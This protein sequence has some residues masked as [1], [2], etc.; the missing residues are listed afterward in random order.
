M[1]RTATSIW[2]DKTAYRQQVRMAAVQV[3][4]LSPDELRN[5]LAYEIEP[6]SGVSAAAAEVAWREIEDPD[7]SVRV[8]EVAV[9]DGKSSKSHDGPAALRNMRCLAAIAVLAVAAAVAD[10]ALLSG[11][12]AKLEKTVAEQSVLDAR[13][14]AERAK[15]AAARMAAERIRAGREAAARA[16]R[17]VARL[18]GAYPGIMATL[19]SVCGGRVVVKSLAADKPFELKL[20]AVAASADAAAATMA[21]LTK[22]VSSQG[23]TLAPGPIA[24]AADGLTAEFSCVLALSRNEE[25][26]L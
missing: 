11:R 18:R 5:A 1:A 17:E 8:Y 24:A 13:V 26:A 20:T 14:S 19:A 10:W 23:W 9:R 16:Q 12:I 22:A 25:G 15:A 4:A 7:K 6:F 2:D 21:E 3:E